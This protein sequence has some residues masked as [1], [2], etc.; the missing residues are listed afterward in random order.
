MITRIEA[1]QYRSFR[2]LNQSLGPLHILV[3]PNGSGK[4]VFMDVIAFLRDFVSNGLEA[5]VS[6]RTE[7]FQDLVWGRSGTCFE[8]SIEAL[9]SE[10]ES[11]EFSNPHNRTIRYELVFNID[12]LSDT[13]AVTKETLILDPDQPSS[14]YVVNRTVANVQLQVEDRHMASERLSVGGNYSALVHLDKSQYPASVWL[15]E[16]LQ[17]RT[18]TVVLDNKLL[19][20]PS[21]PAKASWNVLDGSNLARLVFQLQTESPQSFD[22]WVEHIRTALPDLVTIRTVLRPEDRHRY[23]MLR[24]RGEV[25]A[26]SWVVSDGTLRLLALTILAYLPSSKGIYLVEEPENG[27][28]PTALETIYQ[29]LSSVYDGQVFVTSH[30]PVLLNLPKLQELLCFQKTDE[31]SRIIRGDEH[32]ALRDWKRDVSMSDLFAAGVLG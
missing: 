13:L 19:R 28:H 4:S 17:V 11:A 10:E 23:I 25:E 5:A 9:I 8:L 29:S 12:S 14:P 15:R 1:K 30:S 22:R 20:A 26:P 6:E 2:T 31:G 16:L 24:Y 21:A 3:G 32:P 18:R 7:N 27:V